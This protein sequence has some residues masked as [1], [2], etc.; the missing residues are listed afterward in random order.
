MQRRSGVQNIYETLNKL[1][2]DLLAHVADACTYRY[3]L[4]KRAHN[5]ANYFFEHSPLAYVI[6]TTIS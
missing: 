3:S 6:T 5:Y 1:S 4:D 2:D